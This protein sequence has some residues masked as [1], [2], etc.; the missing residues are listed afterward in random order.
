[1]T[2]YLASQRSFAAKRRHLGTC[3]S[4]LRNAADAVFVLLSEMAVLVH[5]REKAEYFLLGLVV[6]LLFAFGV[7]VW[8]G[9]AVVDRPVQ[10]QLANLG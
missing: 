9:E 6:G 5:M 8:L 2:D 3:W 1:M 7:V 4:E 10:V